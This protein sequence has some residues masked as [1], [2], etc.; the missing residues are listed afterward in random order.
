MASILIC[1]KIKIIREQIFF[2]ILLGILVK[3]IG[4]NLN[5][6]FGVFL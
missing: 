4:L 3:K 5:D 1:Y 6:I 2:L